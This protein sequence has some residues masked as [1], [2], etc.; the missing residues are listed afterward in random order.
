MVSVQITSVN[1]GN[2]GGFRMKHKWKRFGD[3]TY[4]CTKCKELASC[5]ADWCDTD[6]IIKW[7]QK[8][9]KRNDCSGKINVC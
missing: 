7:F 2:F 1:G 4:R 5:T 8:T 6:G 3:G 9:A